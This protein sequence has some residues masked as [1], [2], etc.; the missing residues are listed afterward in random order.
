[1]RDILK[2]KQGIGAIWFVILAFIVA[3]LACGGT[4]QDRDLWSASGR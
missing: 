4:G 2:Y 3:G 1:M